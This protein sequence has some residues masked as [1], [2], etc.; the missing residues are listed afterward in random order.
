MDSL[1]LDADGALGVVAVVAVLNEATPLLDTCI[2]VAPVLCE[3]P[4]YV[5]RDGGMQ[6][7]CGIPA[8]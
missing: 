2:V 7:G 8:S 5:K 6:S 3:A 4:D 1:K